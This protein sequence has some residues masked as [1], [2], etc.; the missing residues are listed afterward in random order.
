MK[1]NLPGL[2]TARSNLTSV[3]QDSVLSSSVLPR[4]LPRAAKQM[5]PNAIADSEL[6]PAVE[7]LDPTLP[8]NPVRGAPGHQIKEPF[9][10]EEDEDGRSVG[11]QLVEKGMSDAEQDTVNQS[12]RRRGR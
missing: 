4:T 9:V 12:A 11:E 8:V 7:G 2:K 5:K 10:D 6:D 1:K 3:D